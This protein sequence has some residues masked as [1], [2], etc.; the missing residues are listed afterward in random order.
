MIRIKNNITP[1]LPDEYQEVEYVQS[2]GTQYINT[3]I[4]PNSSTRMVIDVAF[5]DINTRA[6]NGWGSSAS[7]ESFFFGV[8]G[9]NNYFLASVSSNYTY[10]YS[11]IK[12]DT[13]RHSFDISNSAIKIDGISCGT[14]NIGNTATS[15]QTLYLF[16]LHTEYQ[17]NN[18][19]YQG[20]AEKIY[21]CQIYESNVLVRDFVPCYRKSD[22]EIGLYDLVNGVFYTNQG[23]GT[24]L[25]SSYVEIQPMIV[26]HNGNYIAPR[27]PTEYEEVEYIESTG[28]QYIDTGIV[29][30]I[31]N[32]IELD[33][34][35]TDIS[36]FQINGLFWNNVA[37]RN[38]I[39]IL[40]SKVFW[41]VSTNSVTSNTA[42]DTNRHTY[43]INCVDGSYGMDGLTIGSVTPSSS[44]DTTYT[45]LLGARKTNAG[46]VEAYCYEKIY[47]A[48]YYVSGTLVRNFVPCYRKLDNVVGMYDLVSNA[49]YTNQG[50]GVFLMGA[51]ISKYIIV[52]KI[53]K[54]Y[55]GE[56]LVFG[57]EIDYEQKINYMMLYDN[58]Y[59]D[60]TENQCMDVT[61]G[62]TSGANQGQLSGGFFTLDDTGMSFG[63]NS[64]SLYGSKYVSTVNKIPVSN[65][66]KIW[67]KL[68][69]TPTI[70]STYSTL[71]NYDVPND[72]SFTPGSSLY[73][74]STY[75][76]ARIMLK[77]YYSTG[78]YTDILTH[79]LQNARD[80]DYIMLDSESSATSRYMQTVKCL[81]L[82]LLKIDDTET[83][84]IEAGLDPESY[85]GDDEL[86]ADN[87]AITTILSN[88]S[89][90]TYMITNCT[91]SFMCEFIANDNCLTALNNSPYK[92]LIQANEHWNKFLNMV[93]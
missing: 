9:D 64:T 7:A 92:T 77:R 47:G 24:F 69:V 53:L 44:N 46:A 60:A 57:K 86:C 40:N 51:E 39:G 55:I 84:C 83:L 34:Q 11:N 93:A 74:N 8:L 82:A 26:L 89:A 16:A 52:K 63:D 37:M 15:T 76:V 33:V 38:D 56:N 68:T 87:T 14:G 75:Q 72:E 17:E 50:T 71:L 35:Y 91:G 61:G 79:S 25:K 66:K 42:G 29:G 6:R 30:S 43:F 21:S 45:V 73:Q 78:I 80:E 70:P 31:K 36:A 41:G 13:N 27:L 10:T 32:K 2:T 65:Y 20:A 5:N 67:G 62:W 85:A 58:S 22:N 18:L 90:V 12:K 4:V 54:R 49:F 48:K 1:R 88:K 28:T 23:T 19:Y 59:N 81:K 3:G